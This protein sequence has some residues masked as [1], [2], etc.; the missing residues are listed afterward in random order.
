MPTFDDVYPFEAPLFVVHVSVDGQLVAYDL[1]RVVR[2]YARED[3]LYLASLNSACTI[4]QHDEEFRLSVR[5]QHVDGSAQLLTWTHAKIYPHPAYKRYLDNIFPESIEADYPNW[6]ADKLEKVQMMY[7]L[8]DNECVISP[9]TTRVVRD[10]FEPFYDAFRKVRFTGSTILEKNLFLNPS[11]VCEIDFGNLIISL[12]HCNHLCINNQVLTRVRGRNVTHINCLGSFQLCKL[13]HTVD[14]PRLKSCGERTFHATFSLQELVA[15]DLESIGEKCFFRAGLLRAVFPRLHTA[16]EKSFSC[17]QLRE[18]QL[19]LLENVAEYCF[20]HCRLLQ[21]VTLAS[22]VS[23]NRE[24]FHSCFALTEVHL[25]NV[26][27]CTGSMQF[28]KCT[29][30]EQCVLPELTEISILMFS[31]CSKLRRVAFPAVTSIHTGA[32]DDCPGLKEIYIPRVSHIDNRV[33]KNLR[34]TVQCPRNQKMHFPPGVIL[35]IGRFPPL[36]SFH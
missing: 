12:D 34:A 23:L 8:Q 20:D 25:Q 22:A 3:R 31:C 15:P 4:H 13:L 14:L 5:G 11:N 17:S 26:T 1:Y 9:L 28:Y 16:G 36:A 7:R 35:M 32:F 6:A 10:H 27:T 30:L 21:A 33:F 18:V 19:P 24:C 29:S 2:A